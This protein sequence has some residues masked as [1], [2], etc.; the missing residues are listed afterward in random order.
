MSHETKEAKLTFIHNPGCREYRFDEKGSTHIIL[1]VAYNESVDFFYHQYHYQ[2]KSPLALASNMEYAGF[3]HY[4]SRRIFDAAYRLFDYSDDIKS[5]SL[6]NLKKECEAAIR[7]ALIDRINNSPVPVTEA[8]EE[9]TGK[10][11]YHMEHGAN[12]DARKA[13]FCGKIQV[14]YSP[15]VSITPSTEDTI[16]MVMDMDQFVS[17][18][19][20]EYLRR[21]AKHI[22]ER[23]W[24]NSVTQE[25]LVEMIS[26]PGVH[27]TTLAIAKCL[28]GD[29]KTVNVHVDKEDVRLTVKISAHTLAVADTYYYSTYQMDATG[30]KTFEEFFGRNAHL[31][32]ADIHCIT[33][34]KKVLYERKDVQETLL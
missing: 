10:R 31:D 7:A 13:F 33:Y 4:P 19:V 17:E 12:Q 8:A 28:T 5:H 27:H 3:V 29:M 9:D 20:D 23:L 2:V 21:N 32:P 30:R 34:G 15:Y 24:E 1:K 11:E 26:S 14:E 25:R 18:Y 16:R 6:D 22:N